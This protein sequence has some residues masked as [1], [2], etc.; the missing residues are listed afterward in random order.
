MVENPPLKM[1][2]IC[3]SISSYNFHAKVGNKS[4]RSSL[5]L[6][7]MRLF[8]VIFNHSDNAEAAST[9]WISLSFLEEY[10]D[11]AI[12]LLQH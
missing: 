6:V 7:E 10:N 2:H 9:T 3:E 1:S 4:N 8:Q 12:W 5:H 11:E